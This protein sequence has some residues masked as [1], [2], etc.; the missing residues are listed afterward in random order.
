[1]DFNKTITTLWIT[2]IVH[3]YYI[4]FLIIDKGIK[5]NLGQLLPYR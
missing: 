2:L 1:M 4:K 3:D 5:D